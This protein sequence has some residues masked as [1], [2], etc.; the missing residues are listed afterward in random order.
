M[1]LIKGIAKKDQK[2]VQILAHYMKT[3]RDDTGELM[4]AGGGD[5]AGIADELPLGSRRVGNLMRKYI[6]E[7][8]KALGYR[9]GI[10]VGASY[11][12]SGAGPFGHYSSGKRSVRNRAGVV[13]E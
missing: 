1:A 8:A 4:W 5:I 10:Y 9:R 12:A 7:I 6:Q 11:H 13:F 3:R 2:D